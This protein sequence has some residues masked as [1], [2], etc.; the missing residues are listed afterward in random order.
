MTNETESAAPVAHSAVLAAF[1]DKILNELLEGEWEPDGIWQQEMLEHAK[2]I[3]LLT[4][5]PAGPDDGD[6]YDFIYERV[7]AANDKLS[8]S[9]LADGSEHERNP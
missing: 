7:P 1:G 5:R 8:D 6:E 2:E 3:G 9:R 4:V